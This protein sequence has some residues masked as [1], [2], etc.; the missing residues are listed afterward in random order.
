MC[1]AAAAPAACPL[2]YC[3]SPQSPGLWQHKIGG[4]CRARP[5][6]APRE[7]MGGGRGRPQ[8]LPPSELCSPSPEFDRSL[9]ARVSPQGPAS[10][11]KGFTL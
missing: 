3:S 1:V 6:A 5:V 4:G 9:L 7:R 2:C 10:R 8:P 11:S